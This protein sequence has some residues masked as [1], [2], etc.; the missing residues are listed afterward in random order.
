MIPLTYSS[1]LLISAIG[2][3]VYKEQK[4][5]L[6]TLILKCNRG[7]RFR[8]TYYKPT[9]DDDTAI[10]LDNI[11]AKYISQPIYKSIESLDH[12][13]IKTIE[14]LSFKEFQAY[15][16]KT[17]NTIC[18]RHPIAV[19]LAALQELQPN[20]CTAKCL[21][22]DQSSHCEKYLDSSVSYAS[23]YVQIS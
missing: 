11:N 22:Y 21:K 7:S 1:F 6:L 14:N 20:D 8:Y 18:G 3:K 17:K 9:D 12:Q 4:T 2:K 23:I 15:L 13:G 5:R 16:R 10:E 19:L